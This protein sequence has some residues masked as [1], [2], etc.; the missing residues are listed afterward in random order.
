MRRIPLAKKLANGA[1]PFSFCMKITIKKQVL[2]APLCVV[3][4]FAKLRLRFQPNTQ[5]VL[6]VERAVVAAVVEIHAHWE[7][8]K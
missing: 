2:F 7:W 3:P 6:F 5:L 1:G 4:W 8:L